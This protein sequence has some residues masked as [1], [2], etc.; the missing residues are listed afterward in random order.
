MS[1]S[2]HSRY[3]GASGGASPIPFEELIEVAEAT[4]AAADLARTS[5]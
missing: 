2:P 1:S 3:E 5:R 4:I